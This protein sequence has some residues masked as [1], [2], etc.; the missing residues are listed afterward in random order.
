[1]STLGRL[2]QHLAETYSGAARDALTE[3]DAGMLEAIKTATGLDEAASNRLLATVGATGDR[4]KML[5]DIALKS[6]D[7]N[8][9][10][11][12]FLAQYGLDRDKTMY[13]IQNGQM[14]LILPLLNAFLGYLNGTS[15]GYV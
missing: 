2:N 9:E 3:G 10:W 1:M 5:S 13:D 7:Q 6:L 4:Q 12:K 15:G 11:N 14:G 8:I